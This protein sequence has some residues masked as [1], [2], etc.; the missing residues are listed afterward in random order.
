MK[1]NRKI[2]KFASFSKTSRT[3]NARYDATGIDEYE[4][5]TPVSRLYVKAGYAV[6]AEITI[7]GMTFKT[8][9]ESALAHTALRYVWNVEE[10]LQNREP[11]MV[12]PYG[13]AWQYE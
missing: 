11:E 8:G 5:T 10:E 4:I 13:E 3:V 7:F 1:Y 2:N 9:I 12:D 6:E